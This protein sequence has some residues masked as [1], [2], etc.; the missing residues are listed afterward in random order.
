MNYRASGIRV[1]EIGS[2]V[3][4]SW[5]LECG[6]VITRTVRG[7]P[8]ETPTFGYRQMAPTLAG[9]FDNPTPTAS[10]EHQVHDYA[11]RGRWDLEPD[12]Y[13][14]NFAGHTGQFVFDAHGVPM[15]MPYQKLV[16]T[17]RSA[18]DTAGFSITAEDGT[19][20]H[21]L[22]VE[23][24]QTETLGQEGELDYPSSWYLTRI[25]PV[26][27]PCIKFRYVAGTIQY[28]VNE[29]ETRYVLLKVEPANVPAGTGQVPNAR[30]YTQL[31]VS[32]L[33]L[34]GVETR[35]ERVLF[36]GSTRF[37][38]PGGNRLDSLTVQDAAGQVRK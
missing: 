13:S 34:T 1:D 4:V 23:R 27:G 19:R 35:A 37:D 31:T 9:Y 16:I 10:F 3:S 14:F 18:A 38:L 26:A 36:Y 32:A 15:A 21:F 6:G 8:D 30:T 5:S 28:P 7:L 2:W 22:D 24:S 33:T 20:F 17:E 12:T 29:A 25:E 11:A